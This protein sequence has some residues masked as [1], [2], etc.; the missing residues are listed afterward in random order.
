M[1]HVLSLDQGTTSS[2]AII[3]NCAGDIV[4]MAQLPFKQHFPKP[5]WVE[6]NPTDI[7]QS[8][9]QTA[10]EAIKASGLEPKDIS[11][12]GITNQRETTIVWDRKTGEPVYPAI[13]WQDRRTTSFCEELRSKGLEHDIQAR[14][15]LVLDA[16]FCATKV[17]WIL[18]QV[19]GARQRAEQ[20][21][22]AFG[23]VD[24]WLTWK[25]TE[26]QQ[27]VTDPS[28]ASRTML[29]NLQAMDWDDELLDLFQI[30][31][32]ILPRILPS[33]AITGASVKAHLGAEIP[34]AARI[35]DQQAAMFGQACYSP[36]SVKN[37][38]GTGCFMLMNLGDRPVTS[39][40]KLLTTVGWQ[41]PDNKPTYCLEGSVFMGGATIQWLRDQLGF[42]QDAAEV[43]TLAKQVSDSHDVYLVPAFTGLG[44][45]YWDGHARGM[46]IGMT[47]GTGRAHIARAALE[48]IALQVTDVLLA[49][50]SDGQASLT[51]LRVDGGASANNLLMQIQADLLGIPVVR[52]TVLETTALGAAYLAGLATD[53]WSSQEDLA[54]HWQIDRIFEPTTTHSQRQRKIERWHDAVDR[55]KRWA[56]SEEQ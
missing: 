5:G 38:Y 7:W 12:I 9:L 14:T 45:P 30:P 41:L 53:V 1:S 28:N 51:E 46:L 42:I 17:K 32:A 39:Q 50:Q 24:T 56:A 4:G 36:G 3:F 23:T 10:Q 54:H 16:Y 20:G 33:N 31:K 25:L 29:F 19:P 37:T 13:V 52:P 2:R 15:G 18:D 35:G 6:H 8:Q 21:E 43:E 48:G 34:I 27:H 47:R 26:G 49:M 40:S 11:G 55:A 22:L 44:A